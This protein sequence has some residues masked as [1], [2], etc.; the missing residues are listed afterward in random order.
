MMRVAVFVDAGYIF[1]QDS[2]ELSRGKPSRS[3]IELDFGAAVSAL[4]RFVERASKLPLLRIYWYE[5]SYQ[6]PTA[7]QIAMAESDDVKVR[8]GENA[9]QNA[10]RRN[11]DSSNLPGLQF[12]CTPL[13]AEVSVGIVGL[14]KLTTSNQNISDSGV[15]HSEKDYIRKSLPDSLYSEIMHV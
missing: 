13:E 5:A 12:L 10:S 15:L 7:V 11:A 4:R 6:G 2:F 14:I 3:A 1:A 9:S 8:L